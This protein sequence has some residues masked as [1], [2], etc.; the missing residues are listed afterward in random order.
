MQ[1]VLLALAAFVLGTG[2]TLAADLPVRP[3]AKA[4]A[5]ASVYNWT[6]F[7]VGGNAGWIWN[8]SGATITPGN[9]AAQTFFTPTIDV[10]PFLPLSS[11]AFIGG[12]QAGYNWQVD[13]TWVVGVEADIQGTGLK[14]TAVRPGPDDPSRIMTATEKLD[15]FGTLRGRIGV[16]PWDRGLLYVTGGLAYGHVNVSTALT[17]PGFGGAAGNGCGGANNCQAGSATDTRFG[18]TV[19]AGFE[20]AFHQNWSVKGEYLYYDLGSLS[21]RMTDPFFPA[22]F[23]ASADFKGSIARAGINYRWGGPVVAKY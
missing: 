14:T 2:T 7:Y 10:A 11:N 9:G 17:R 22:V 15:W 8:K 1:R 20:W 16:T 6:G 13:P 23:N 19:G 3:Y 5:I 4:P 21:Y 12:G 18:W